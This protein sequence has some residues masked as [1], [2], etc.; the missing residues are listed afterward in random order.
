MIKRYWDFIKDSDAILVLNLLKKEIAGYVGGSVLME[1]GSAYGH[2]KKIFL[3][4]PIPERS[5][6][7]HYVDELMDLE[8]IVID[9][10]LTQ[11]K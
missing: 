3:Y 5:E 9:G 8:P 6:K 11:I 4:N 10:D 1:M 2:G 7:I